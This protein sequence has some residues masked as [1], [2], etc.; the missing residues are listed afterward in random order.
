MSDEASRRP[1]DSV[2]PPG[3]SISLGN[4]LIE[5]RM[6]RVVALLVLT[7]SAPASGTAQMMARIDL[8]AGGRYVWHGIS[9]ADG[10]VAQPSA[11]LG[12]EIRQFSLEGG[13]VLHYELHRVS[14]GELS[15]AG[16]GEARLG[17][18]DFWG[19]ALLSLG[20]VR[21]STG[22]VRYQFHGDSGR[23][24]IGPARSTSEVYAAVSTT[25]PTFTNSLEAW[26]D[27]D[28]VRGAFLRASVDAPV[29][30]WPFPPYAFLFIEGEA[31]LNV[32]QKANFAARGVTHVGLGAGAEVRAGQLGSVGWATLAAGVRSQLN[33][34][35]ATRV[36]GVGRTRDI[37]VWL[38][39]G[40][41]VLLGRTARSVQ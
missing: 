13:A 39:T 21:L 2:T 11:A 38:W 19:R 3:V 14:P 30:A 17:E 12:F 37:N 32:G 27:V 1:T 31:G 28:R 33:L 20:P 35:D 41:T 25:S 26:W 7:V 6:S 34:D 4:V 24:G 9:R 5:H 29:L 40:V 36:E 10:V 8:T 16:S 23:G 18:E 22:V 15:E